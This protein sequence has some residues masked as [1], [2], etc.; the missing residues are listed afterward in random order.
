MRMRPQFREGYAD[1]E[2]GRG[3]SDEAQPRRHREH[4]RSLGIPRPF[5]AKGL[6]STSGPG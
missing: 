1:D 5:A 3:F 2:R 6:M 4:F